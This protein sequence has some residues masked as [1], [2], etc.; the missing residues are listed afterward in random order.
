MSSNLP[1]PANSF[2]SLRLLFALLVIV[3]HSFALVGLADPLEVYTEL[4]YDFGKLGVTG[5][6]AMSGYLVTRSW[7]GNPNPFRFILARAMRIVPAFWLALLF[8][9]L[10]ASIA[11]PHPLEFLLDELTWHWV[12][13]NAFFIW[14]GYS[15]M[16]PGAFANNPIPGGA[17]GSL[18][19]LTY[20][21]YCY[22]AIGLLGIAR[23]FTRPQWIWILVAVLLVFYYKLILS[24]PSAFRMAYHDLYLAFATGM[25]VALRGYRAGILLVAVAFACTALGAAL[26][27]PTAHRWIAPTQVL[28]AVAVIR[29]A[30]S[31]WL[32]H[33]AFPSG[34]YS[35]GLYVYAFPVQQ[36][37]I[38]CYGPTT[39]PPLTAALTVAATLPFAMLSWHCVEK[40]ALEFVRTA[41]KRWPLLKKRKPIPHP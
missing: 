35:Y 12:W 30:N 37:I 28:I 19:T 17:N 2:D 22:A 33:L 21:L 11:N 16:T 10:V 27:F 8:S 13:R 25:V 31:T 7:L 41:S 32:S 18:W 20:E 39:P 4:T 36:L 6:F 14:H 23:V 40:R 26:E 29:L 1:R 5:F 9:V 15:S 34:D 38:A 3:T 24:D